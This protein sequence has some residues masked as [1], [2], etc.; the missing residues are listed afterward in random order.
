MNQLGITG[1]SDKI[2]A[3]LHA[4]F[5]QNR[6]QLLDGPHFRVSNEESRIV[7]FPENIDQLSGMLE[8]A[9]VESWRIVPAGAGTWLE[10]GNP[11]GA[12]D[13]I[14]STSRMSRVLEY[15]P[16]D[17]TATVEAGCSLTSFN[18]MA[19]A[20]R[21]FIP[22][23]PF[24][25]ESSTIGATISTASAGPLRCAYGTPRDWL[26]GLRI[27]HADG[28]ITSAGGKVVKNVAGYDLCKLY[29]GSFGTLGIIAEMSFKL[30]AL[31]SDDSTLIFYSGNV[32]GFCELIERIRDSDLSPSAMELISP[33]SRD[34][35][36]EPGRFALALRFLSEPETAAWQQTEAVSMAGGLDSVLFK[37]DQS[38]DFWRKYSAGETAEEW[39]TCLR[40]SSLPADLSDTLADIDNLFPGACTRSHVANGLVRVFGK[41]FDPESI[42]QLRKRAASRGG[43]LVITR[44]GDDLKRTVEVWG[45]PGP[46]ISIM[47]QIRDSFDPH[48]RLNSGRFTV[49]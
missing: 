36:I 27:V 13:L 37:G 18:R 42:T 3:R 39:E 49:E 14:V 12:F 9:A 10:M 28:K 20:D 1:S 24:G 4:E 45:D 22:L 46:T 43:S 35:A 15:E 31:P 40:V 48:R 25:D 32:H 5:G 33:G 26:I 19:A 34:L 8:M 41:A 47:K 7:A 38:A 30:R 21:Q 11:A 23:D 2:L 29:T 44:A 16:A 17:L 6:A